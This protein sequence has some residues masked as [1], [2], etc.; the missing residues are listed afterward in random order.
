MIDITKQYCTR[1]G[2]TVSELRH[3]LFN[4]VQGK[5]HAARPIYTQWNNETGKCIV[6]GCE[7][8]DLVEA[9][10]SDHLKNALSDVA[11]WRDTDGENVIAKLLRDA[12]DRI[13]Q[14]EAA[15]QLIADACAENEWP[16]GTQQIARAALGEKKD[17]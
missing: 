7:D 9:T 8:Y 6:L 14:L 3:A 5:I 13:E 12:R 15:L 17:G 10:A 1:N 11:N 16:D 2:M 4:T